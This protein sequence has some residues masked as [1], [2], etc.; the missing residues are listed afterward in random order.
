M[1]KA[2]DPG[3]ISFKRLS[4]SVSKHGA[5]GISYAGALFDRSCA[6]VERVK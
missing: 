5:E 1:D 4:M 6:R 3:E 2:V